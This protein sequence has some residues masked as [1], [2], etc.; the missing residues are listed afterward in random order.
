[1]R[2]RVLEV[3]GGG[4]FIGNDMSCEDGLATTF[5]T[6]IKVEVPSMSG[7]LVLDRDFDAGLNACYQRPK[8]NGGFVGT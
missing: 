1:L 6:N 4:I 2:A 7:F 3:S 5:W 8:G